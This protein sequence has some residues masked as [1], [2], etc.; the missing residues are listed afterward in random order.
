[1]TPVFVDTSA[2]I[3]LLNRDDEYH[4]AAVRVFAG[5]LE[6]PNR[7]VTHNYVVVETFAVLQARMGVESAG[8]FQQEILPVVHVEWVL[9]QDHD[10]GVGVVLA[11]I[12]R[13]LSLVDC[14]SFAMLRRTG[15]RR[16]FCFDRHFREQGFENAE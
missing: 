10:I 6:G 12:R 13:R 2:F 16:V 1:M 4:E 7:L 15:I 14:T 9:P 8:T 5:L 11:S 3:A